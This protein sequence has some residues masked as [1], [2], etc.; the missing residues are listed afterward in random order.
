MPKIVSNPTAKTIANRLWRARTAEH[1]TKYKTDLAT[2]YRVSR[3][4]LKILDESSARKP[5]GRPK[6]IL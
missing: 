2:W 6:K 3:E 4:F 1:Y 5:V